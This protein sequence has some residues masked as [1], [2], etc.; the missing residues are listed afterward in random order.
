[1]PPTLN[2]DGS[3][4]V[5]EEQKRQREAE[6]KE[7]ERSGNEN[8]QNAA[9]NNGTPNQ[10]RIGSNNGGNGASDPNYPS[11][12]GANQVNFNFPQGIELMQLITTMAQ[13]TG[14]NFILTDDIKG[15]VTVISH[16]PITVKEAYQAF[17]SIFEF[18][19]YTTVYIPQS[20]STKM[21]QQVVQA[22]HRWVVRR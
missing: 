14:R 1:M 9:P 5:L 18:N 2:P 7:E 10:I 8:E 13:I 6:E 4:P 16:K 20:N 17:L 12:I 19:G 21:L 3:S 15:T 22:T 11:L